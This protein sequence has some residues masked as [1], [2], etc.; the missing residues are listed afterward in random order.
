MLKFRAWDGHR[1]I[2]N[3]AVIGGKCHI[4]TNPA[5]DSGYVEVIKNGRVETYYAEWAT[6][7]PKEYPIMQSTGLK[8]RN[9]ADIY[10]SDII[11]LSCGCCKYEVIWDQARLCWWP[12]DDGYSQ[13]HLID[14]NVWDCELTVVGNVYEAKNVCL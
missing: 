2:Y 1:M 9:G 8:D 14:V 10:E 13:Q 5:T 11:E 6:Y 4:E 3:F 7:K 12:K